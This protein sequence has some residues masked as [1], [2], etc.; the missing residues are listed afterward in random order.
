MAELTI[1]QANELQQTHELFSPLRAPHEKTTAHQKTAEYP[2][3][4]NLSFQVYM[5]ISYMKSAYK[6]GPL[7]QKNI[8]APFLA[9]LCTATQV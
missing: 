2:T 4:K 3:Q 9:S 1:I 5:Q 8:H 6:W 7:S